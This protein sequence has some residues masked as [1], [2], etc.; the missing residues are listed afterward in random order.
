VLHSVGRNS[1]KAYDK[2]GTV[3]RVETTIN[4]TRDFKV[5]R[6]HRYVL[7][8]KGRDTLIPIMATQNL[9]IQELKSAA[10]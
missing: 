6:T 4:N 2:Q 7:T 1:V 8:P 5:F 9:T 10:A 3:L